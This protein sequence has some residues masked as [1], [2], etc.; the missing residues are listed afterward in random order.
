VSDYDISLGVSLPTEPMLAMLLILFGFNM[1]F[2]KDKWIN[3][4][5]LFHPISISIIFYLLWMLLTTLT[6]ARFVVSLKFFI[7]K[8]WFIIPFYFISSMVFNHN[9]SF[10]K[11]Y[12]WLYVISFTGII[13]YS[14]IHHSIY[15]FREQQGH[16]VMHPFYNDHT[17][18]GA[19]IAFFIP[20]IIYNIIDNCQSNS[21][22]R[23]ALFLGLLYVVALIFSYT[24]AA[25]LSIVVALICFLLIIFKIRL[26]NFTLL[27][28]I[29][30]VNLYYFRDTIERSLD[31]NEAVSSSNFYKHIKSMYN[32][33]T[34]VSN[35]E[36]LN[37]WKCAIRM[38][39]DKPL[40]GFGPGTYQFE[41]APYQNPADKT[42]I[43]TNAGIRGNAHSEYLGPLSEEGVLGLLSVLMIVILTIYYGLNNIKNITDRSYKLLNIAILL[44]LIT[45]FTHGL[46]NNFLDTDKASAPFWGTIA[47]I[48]V[49]NRKNKKGII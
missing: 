3:K 1:I 16:W 34:D 11:R 13:C 18:Y 38:F 5:I 10:I 30:T 29:I 45:Y 25:W 19:M 43:S 24:R 40:V 33:K 28:L 20:F 35:K 23:V 8:L 6:S 7:A 41:Y 36:R 15:D 42:V 31:R 48:V 22:R 46:L 4:E 47:A 26:I 37:R 27:M 32:V 2:S 44:S 39:I 9:I 17:S 14:L 12:L 21:V 49:M